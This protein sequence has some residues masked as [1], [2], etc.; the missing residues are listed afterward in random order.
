MKLDRKFVPPASPHLKVGF[1]DGVPFYP[2]EYDFLIERDAEEYLEIK[3]WV[4]AELMPYMTRK[5]INERHSSYG[6]KHVAE[7]E[8]G[9]YVCNADIKL[10]LLERDVRFK[11]YYESPNVSYPLNEEFYKR[12]RHVERWAEENGLAVTISY[13]H[14]VH[15]FNK[16]NNNSE[17]IEEHIG[18]Y[19]TENGILLRDNIANK[20]EVRN[21]MTG[22]WEKFNFEHPLCALIYYK[23]KDEYPLL[24]RSDFQ[25][26][27]EG[28]ARRNPY[29]KSLG[30]RD[31]QCNP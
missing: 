29:P 16:I 8:L 11:S 23:F 28:I 9:F 22:R 7:R 10:I 26:R 21:K 5:T 15:D 2:S 17:K 4:N 19:L 27:L 13:K 20:Y 30:E 6:L 3:R 1:I 12:R 31:L 14:I 25:K 24:D 18:E